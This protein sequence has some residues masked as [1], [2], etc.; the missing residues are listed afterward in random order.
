VINL[1]KED[2]IN[3]LIK[4]LVETGVYKNE[5]IALKDIIVT[6]I[7]NK[8]NNYNTIISNLEKKHNTT[9]SAFTENL[10]NNA[11]M[12]LEDDWMDL[13]AAFTMKQA[14]EQ[15]LKKILQDKYYV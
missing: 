13:K 10:K 2:Y 1:L 3:N 5:K 6:H 15:A 14:W 11:S 4:P 9:F 8:L 12:E 7:E